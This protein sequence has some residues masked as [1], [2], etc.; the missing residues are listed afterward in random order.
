MV[1]ATCTRFKGTMYFF[2]F[3]FASGGNHQ[4]LAFIESILAEEGIQSHLYSSDPSVD[5]AFQMG[6]K[7]G[8]LFIVVPPPGE[9]S[10]SF[11]SREK[12]V[13][14]RADLKE[15]GFSSANLK[16]TNILAGEG[17]EA[18]KT[19][20]KDLKEGLPFKVMYPDGLIFLVEKR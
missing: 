12:E 18:I 8:M 13:I 14:V 1:A 6:E 20:A 4:K 17:A 11:E 7:K 15:L 16:L 5:V 3:D 10:D 19:S 2:C 9:L